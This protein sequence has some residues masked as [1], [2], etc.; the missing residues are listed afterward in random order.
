MA[1]W[2]VTSSMAVSLGKYLA[3]LGKEVLWVPD[4]HLGSYI[5]NKSKA[6]VYSWPGK[7]IVP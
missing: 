6:H 5:E 7:C 1:D 3:S 4:R 2:I